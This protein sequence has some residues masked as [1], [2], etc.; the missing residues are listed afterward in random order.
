MPD[1]KYTGAKQA[2][3]RQALLACGKK[4]AIVSTPLLTIYRFEKDQLYA[5]EKI[6]Q[7]VEL[8][9]APV[10]VTNQWVWVKTWLDNFG[11]N[12]P[13]WFVA[14]VKDNTPCA[15]ALITK[16]ANRTLPLP[17]SAYHI[18]TYGESYKDWIHM[19]NNQLLAKPVV[20]KQ[21]IAALIGL[22]QAEPGWEEISLDN[23]CL[24][25]ALLF[26]LEAGKQQYTRGYASYLGCK[27]VM[28]EI[29]CPTIDLAIVRQTTSD[30][31]SVLSYDLRYAIRR[32]IRALGPGLVCEWATTTKQAMAIFADLVTLHQQTWQRRGKRGMFASQRFTNFHK[33][34]I[35]QL[36]PK[37][38]VIL[39]RVISPQYGTIGCLYL[40]VDNGV[41][42]GYQCGFV[43]FTNRTIKGINAKRL[44]PGFVVHALCMQACLENGIAEYNFSVGERQYKQEL[45]TGSRMLATVSLRKSMKP[46]LRDVLL[47]TY[48]KVDYSKRMRFLVK[49]LYKLL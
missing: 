17:V 1:M 16:E 8:A 26:Q 35:R 27:V 39:F 41:A 45:A 48:A 9:C 40:F 13:Y 3:T 44:K 36:L 4:D 15:V 38:Q 25:D 49:P 21:F 46:Y 33:A 11:T 30:I 34:I 5:V 19:V 6:W 23:F 10:A 14:G 32:N 31:L 42:Y 20:K 37:E 28:H 12:M 43:D 18:G 47:K 2:A 22:L 24:P 7:Q 29:A